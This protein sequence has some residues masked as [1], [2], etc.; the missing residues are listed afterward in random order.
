MHLHLL[1]C[2]TRHGLERTAWE[3]RVSNLTQQ[4]MPPCPKIMWLGLFIGFEALI[5][6]IKRHGTMKSLL[7][8]ESG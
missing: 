2:E 6:E 7:L 4:M 3:A 1:K 8:V 5:Y